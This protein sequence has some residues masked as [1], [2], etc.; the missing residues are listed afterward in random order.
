MNMMSEMSNSQN[1]APITSWFTR[2][3]ICAVEQ[4]LHSVGILS[5]SE[6]RILPVENSSVCILEKAS[7][8]CSKVTMICCKFVKA[9]MLACNHKHGELVI[10]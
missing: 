9:C 3:N 7:S 10:D 8:I 2:E 1:K 4:K 5:G 6:N